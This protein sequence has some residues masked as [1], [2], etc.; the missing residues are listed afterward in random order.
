[1]PEAKDKNSSTFRSTEGK[2]IKRL[3]GKI[4]IQESAL[5]F[6]SIVKCHGEQDVMLSA[7]DAC[8]PWLE[9]Q[10]DIIQPQLILAIGLD[11]IQWFAGPEGDESLN[12]I[13]LRW[14]SIPVMPVVVVPLKGDEM[15]QT[16]M[17]LMKAS[18]L[19]WRIDGGNWGEGG[20]GNVRKRTKRR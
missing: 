6:T 4:H 1:M 15:D 8:A 9:R 20:Y 2:L 14:R 19:L 11:A 16:A 5:F 7:I 17:A 18:S 13:L 3:I 12:G 10:I